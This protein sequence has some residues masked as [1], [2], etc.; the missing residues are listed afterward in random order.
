[1]RIEAVVL[2]CVQEV[3]ISRAFLVCLFIGFGH[4]HKEG[5]DIEEMQVV[6]L[7]MFRFSRGTGMCALPAFPWAGRSSLQPWLKN[8]ALSHLVGSE[9]PASYSEI[10]SI[11]GGLPC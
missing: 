3:L 7:G 5:E 10:R 11:A 1:M 2:S 9:V 8:P 6:M 4:G